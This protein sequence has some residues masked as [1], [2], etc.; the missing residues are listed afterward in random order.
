MGITWVLVGIE[1]ASPTQ[2]A[3]IPLYCMVNAFQKLS[4]YVTLWPASSWD[5]REL[6]Q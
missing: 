1:N 3:G 4:V 6:T 2:G 5:A